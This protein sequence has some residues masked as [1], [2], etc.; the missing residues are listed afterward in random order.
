MDVAPT[1]IEAATPSSPVPPG[2]E[3][4]PLPYADLPKRPDRTLVAGHAGET[5]LIHGAEFA[6]FPNPSNGA[7]SQE[8]S[9]RLWPPSDPSSEQTPVME[10]N[11]SG[12]SRHQRL[13]R[14]LHSSRG[15]APELPPIER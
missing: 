13:K 12:R 8:A 2:M 4:M 1:L 7:D 15:N 11:A 3:G 9:G 10:T 14:L 6:L 5:L